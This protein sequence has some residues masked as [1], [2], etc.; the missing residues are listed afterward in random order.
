MPS[1]NP[2]ISKILCTTI[3]RS[4]G[5]H[6]KTERLPRGS[7]LVIPVRHR[8]AALLVSIARNDSAL[9]RRPP[10][11]TPSTEDSRDTISRKQDYAPKTIRSRGKILATNFFGIQQTKESISDAVPKEKPS[12]RLRVSQP[13]R[14]PTAR[15][16]RTSPE[17][18]GG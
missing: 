4:S 16:H 7:P 13:L 12:C 9:I 17:S 8:C 10:A 2:I 14:Q 11:R 5:S 1:Y 6:K 18:S 3:W 15:S